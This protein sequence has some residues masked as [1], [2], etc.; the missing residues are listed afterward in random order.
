MLV[1]FTNVSLMEFQVRYLVLFLL[2]SL[3]FEWFWIESLHKNIQVMREFLKAPFLVLHLSYYTLMT[4]PMMLSVILPSMVMMLLSIQIVIGH[5]ICGNNLDW[6]L[7]LNLIYETVDWSKKWLVDFKAGKA[8]M[9]SFDRSNNNCS[10]DVK[11]GRSILE[12]KSC[13][14]MIDL[15]F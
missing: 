12:E 15:V 13:F 8:Q 6:L 10:I 5:L 4:F 14:K 1:S 2:F 9:V 3:G 11:M 7:N